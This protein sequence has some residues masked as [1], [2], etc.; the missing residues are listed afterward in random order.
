[1]S[2]EGQ[3][4]FC[5]ACVQV[6]P[7]HRTTVRFHSAACSTATRI[8]LASLGHSPRWFHRGLG[9]PSTYCS[10]IRQPRQELPSSD[11]SCPKLRGPGIKKIRSSAK[12]AMPSNELYLQG[13]EQLEHPASILDLARSHPLQFHIYNW[14]LQTGKKSSS[15]G[16][17]FTARV[18][19][20]ELNYFGT[21]FCKFDLDS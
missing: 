15:T 16:N 10:T 21:P 18:K 19:K 13:T 5:S 3:H 9:L 1:M 6:R 2:V 11:C 12:V 7:A 14:S 17:L 8:D 20:S 4:I